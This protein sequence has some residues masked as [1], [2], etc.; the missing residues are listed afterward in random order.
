MPSKLESWHWI[1]VVIFRSFWGA[2]SVPKNGLKWA[3]KPRVDFAFARHSFTYFLDLLENY[4]LRWQTVKEHGVKNIAS[5]RNILYHLSGCAVEIFEFLSIDKIFTKK[6]CWSEF[7]L[8]SQDK[9]QVIIK[10]RKGVHCAGRNNMHTRLTWQPQGYCHSYNCRTS[11]AKLCRRA[12]ERQQRGRQTPI[13]DQ[14]AIVQSGW[15]RSVAWKHRFSGQCFLMFW[16]KSWPRLVLLDFFFPFLLVQ[17]TESKAGQL[18]CVVVLVSCLFCSEL[19][20]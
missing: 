19:S 15:W 8:I 3:L 11:K 10:R 2:V 13:S 1:L 6:S 4:E 9:E 20:Q 14:R 16:T 7:I 17:F 12:L 5:G 18:L